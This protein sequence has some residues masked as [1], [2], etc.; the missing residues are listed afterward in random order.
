MKTVKFIL[1]IGILC[2]IETVY[3][4]AQNNTKNPPKKETN[5]ETLDLGGLLG[6]SDDKENIDLDLGKVLDF[7]ESDDAKKLSKQTDKIAKTME[8]GHWGKSGTKNMNEVGRF[9]DQLTENTN[10]SAADKA[11][12]NEMIQMLQTDEASSMEYMKAL[13]E[14]GKLERKGALLEGMSDAEFNK[15]KAFVDY[16]YTS[17][18]NPNATKEER[19]AK[20]EKYVEANGGATAKQKNIM[21]QIFEAERNGTS[22]KKKD[23]VFSENGKKYKLGELLKKNIEEAHQEYEEKQTQMKNTYKNM[24]YEEFRKEF[25][26]SQINGSFDKESIIREIYNET[27]KNGGNKLK[28]IFVVIERHKKS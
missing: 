3:L 17:E 25:D 19:H 5:D 2:C 15:Q 26:N 20:F 9:I 22:T 24:S 8:N 18:H 12:F 13:S 10:M 6:D 4:K 11:H 28:A 7:M 27:Q 21:F 16:F 14:D 1:I 23:I